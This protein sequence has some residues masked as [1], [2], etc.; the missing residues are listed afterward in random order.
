MY[1]TELLCRIY[2]SAQC[3]KGRPGR[4]IPF[5]E[6]VLTIGRMPYNDL[7]LPFESVSGVHGR[8]YR[9]GRQLYFEDL[10]STNGTFLNGYHITRG[11]LV[12][13]RPNDYVQLGRICIGL[14]IGMS[15]GLEPKAPGGINEAAA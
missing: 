11:N 2:P 14:R 13:I 1:Q 7:V 15:G 8:L 4:S 5:V 3:P 12:P 6:T 9:K 10:G